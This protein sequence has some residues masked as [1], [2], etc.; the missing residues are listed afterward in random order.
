MAK[1][2][3]AADIEAELGAGLTG[4]VLEHERQLEKMRTNCQMYGLKPHVLWLSDTGKV[5][6]AQIVAASLSGDV[7]TARRLKEEWEAWVQ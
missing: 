4:D 5:T 1:T 6:M 3:T 7:Q 2:Y